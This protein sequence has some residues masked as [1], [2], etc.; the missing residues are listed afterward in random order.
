MW[1]YSMGEGGVLDDRESQRADK[2]KSI[3]QILKTRRQFQSGSRNGCEVDG[4]RRRLG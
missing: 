1:R 2:G 3:R 4:A